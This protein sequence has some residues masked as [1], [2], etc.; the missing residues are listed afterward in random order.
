MGTAYDPHYRSLVDFAMANL[1]YLS[2]SLLLW[3]M[4]AF[5]FIL[6]ATHTFFGTEPFDNVVMSDSPPPHSL[7][8]KCVH[9]PN[10]ALANLT[11]Y[12]CSKGPERVWYLRGTRDPCDLPFSNVSSRSTLFFRCQ[13]RRPTDQIHHPHTTP[14]GWASNLESFCCL[15]DGAW[16][17][18]L[19]RRWRP[20]HWERQPVV[21]DPA[22]VCEHPWQNRYW[23]CC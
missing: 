1:L 2:M 21:R 14:Q 19:G 20:R 12:E 5:A 9:P 10:T 4:E 8:I 3:G 17:A 6:L 11:S 23:K 13:N 22:D 7:Q 18:L 16:A 15:I